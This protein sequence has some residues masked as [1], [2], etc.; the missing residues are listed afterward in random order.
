MIRIG[1]RGS[2]LALAQARLAAEAIGGETEI[3]VVKTRG[4]RDRAAIDKSKWVA[5]LESAGYR[6]GLL[7]NG[8]RLPE[9]VGLAGYFV[10]VCLQMAT[11][12]PG[13]DDLLI[14]IFGASA[15]GAVA[16]FAGL[17]RR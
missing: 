7:S 3:V 5:E 13:G 4:D 15:A 16:G 10:W 8:S 1:T 6:L 17:F 11:H 2:A 14:G 12:A 9:T